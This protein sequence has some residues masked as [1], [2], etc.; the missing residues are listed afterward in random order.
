MKRVI[1][2][3]TDPVRRTIVAQMVALG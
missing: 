1:V 2:R 3:R